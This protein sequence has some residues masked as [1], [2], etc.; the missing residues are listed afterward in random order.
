MASSVLRRTATLC[1]DT[2]I[3][4]GNKRSRNTAK[5]M[6]LKEFGLKGLRN[7]IHGNS[8]ASRKTGGGV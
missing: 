1:G 3:I 5:N 6:G 4:V 7:E 2:C 8:K